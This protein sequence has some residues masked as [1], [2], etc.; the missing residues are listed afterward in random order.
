MKFR[1]RCKGVFFRDRVF[2]CIVDKP[3]GILSV[4]LDIGGN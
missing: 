3:A 2:G 4:A 1:I